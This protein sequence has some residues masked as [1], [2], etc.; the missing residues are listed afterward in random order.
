MKLNNMKEYRKYIILIIGF[1]SYFILGKIFDFYIPCPVY[2]I[3]GLYCP[4]CG[5]TR[6]FISIFKLDFYQAFRY[7]QLTFI[8]L[9]FFL[10][11]F[12]DYLIS[13]KKNKNSLYKRIPTFVW[14][15]LII[16]FMAFGIIRNI[17]PYFAPTVI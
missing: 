6:M 8:M 4:G 12:I 7:N 9:P 13:I 5:V 10:I 17:I 14:I 3:T 15:I 1:F 2:S 11:L 16:V